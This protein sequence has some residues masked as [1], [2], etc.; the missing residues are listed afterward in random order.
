M[1]VETLQDIGEIG[2]RIDVMEFTRRDQ[3]LDDTD[4]LSAPSS[5]LGNLPIGSRYPYPIRFQPGSME[6]PIDHFNSMAIKSIGTVPS[7]Q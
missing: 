5:V 2:V 7:Y 3:A 4:M 1:L 6:N